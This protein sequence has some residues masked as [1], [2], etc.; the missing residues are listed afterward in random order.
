MLHALPEGAPAGEEFLSAIVAGYEAGV[1]MAMGRLAYAPSGA[2]SPYAVIAAAGSLCRTR[3][4]VMAQ[5]FGI[6]AQT[7]PAFPGLAGLMGCDVKEAIPWGSVTGLAALHLAQ[8]G[9]SGPAQ[10]FDQPTLFAADRI[11]DGLGDRPLIEGT[12]FKPF[13]CCR[14]IHAPLDAYVALSAQRGIAVSDVMGV[15]VHTY[16]ATFNLSNLP[17]PRTLVEAQYSV[18]YCLALCA[19]HGPSAL[20]P[21]DVQLLNDNKVLAFA[22]RVTLHHDTEIEQLFPARSPARVTVTLRGGVRLSSPV[23]DPRGDPSTPLSWEE[24]QAKFLMATARALH[25]ARQT[26]VLEAIRHLRDGDLA[27]LCVALR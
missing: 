10:I 24:L 18:P 20:V 27:P 1:R 14:H 25:P 23:T 17:H 26:E 4:E 13:A 19:V 6:A 2:W 15:E 5:A 11:L 21:M 3:P 7:A 12:Y 9:F 8:E 22:R 16:R